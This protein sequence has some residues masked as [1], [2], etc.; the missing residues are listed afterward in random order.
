MT[1]PGVQHPSPRYRVA[2]DIGG[3][4]TDAVLRRGDGLVRSDKRL[5][6]HGDLLEGLFAAV[7]GVLLSAPRRLAV[8]TALKS[9]MEDRR[10]RIPVS[11][12]LR[13]DLRSIRTEQ[14]ATGAPRLVG[15]T[16]DDGSHGD[17]F[18][19]LALAAAAAEEGGGPVDGLPAGLRESFGV[20]AA[21]GTRPGLEIDAELG[22]VRGR[23]AGLGGFA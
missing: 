2:V 23:S 14:G 10:L 17:R 16:G 1:G 3:T 22:I 11:E 13:T 19:A 18:W 15:D 5:T 4:F 8:A 12:K 7:E 20:F 9:V 6:T 21:P